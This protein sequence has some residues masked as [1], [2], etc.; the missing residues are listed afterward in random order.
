MKTYLLLLASA[1]ALTACGDDNKPK[2]KKAETQQIKPTETAPTAPAPVPQAAPPATVATHDVAEP[3]PVA[4]PTDVQSGY[5]EYIE[6]PMQT[7]SVTANPQVINTSE[8]ISQSLPMETPSNTQATTPMPQNPTM[9]EMVIDGKVVMQP[10]PEGMT[11]DFR[12][13]YLK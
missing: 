1:L 5:K 9:I 7:G 13:N 4:L 10:L 8:E 12:E 3:T 2:K 6:M 11:L